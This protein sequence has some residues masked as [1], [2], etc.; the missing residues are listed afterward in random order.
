MIIELTEKEAETVLQFVDLGL[1]SQG[2]GA[3]A[4]ANMVIDK[5]RN[6]RAKEDE[7]AANPVAAPES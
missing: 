6:A 3:N 2:I 1:K 7:K 5:I 4:A